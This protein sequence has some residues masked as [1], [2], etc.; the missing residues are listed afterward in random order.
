V[1]FRATPDRLVPE[2]S[3]AQELAVLARTLWREGYDDHLAG[4]I[5]IA[6]GDGT[7]WC[8]PW[9]L[10]WQ[11][12][13]PEDVIRIDLDGVVVEGEWPVPLGI[14][15]HLALHRARPDVRVAV[16]SHPLFG[17]VWADAGLVP[18]VLDQ[19]SALGGGELVLVDEYGGTVDDRGAAESAVAAM[20]Q[21]DLALLAGHG[22]LV[23][24]G[25]VRAAHQRAVALEQR[26]ERAWRVRPLVEGPLVSPLPEGFRATMARSD[27]SGFIGF[28]EAAVRAE[29]RADPELAAAIGG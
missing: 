5:T 3:P 2:L 12:L 18:P 4:H 25:S 26:C 1:T 21:A 9:L 20:G 28:W 6:A 19:S 22:V 7:L 29:L 17:V 27:G 11:E 15:L 16:H 24:A 23:V 13:L 14:P 10:T 8:N